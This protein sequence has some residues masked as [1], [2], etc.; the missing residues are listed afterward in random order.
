[1][2]CLEIDILRHIFPVFRNR[3]HF[4]NDLG[5]QAFG[6]F[7]DNAKSPG[8]SAQNPVNQESV[9]RII[10]NWVVHFLIRPVHAVI[11]AINLTEM[12]G[13]LIISFGNVEK[14]ICFL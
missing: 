11:V 2:K 6:I 7:Y 13:P 5:Y 1:M 9:C 3:D 8:I 14:M 4:E 12:A 10:A